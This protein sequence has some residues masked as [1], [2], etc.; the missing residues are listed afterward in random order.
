MRCQNVPKY[1]SSIWKVS[2][3]KQYENVHSIFR[4]KELG[5]VLNILEKYEPHEND[6]FQIQL[7]SLSCIRKW[8]NRK[9]NNRICLIFFPNI[10]ADQ[11]VYFCENQWLHKD[12]HVLTKAEA[13]G[14]GGGGSRF[15]VSIVIVA[16]ST[17]RNAHVTLSLSF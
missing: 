6:Q 8:P 4:N 1:S 10:I 15:D 12:R 11:S 3:P 14:R 13:L 2:S 5:L 16:L 9:V 7:A 17:I